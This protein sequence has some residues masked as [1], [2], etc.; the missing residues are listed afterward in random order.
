MWRCP[1]CRR[2]FANRNQSHFCGNYELGTHFEGKSEA[3]GKLY[4]KFVGRVRRFGPVIIMPEKTRIAF[5]VRMSFAAVQIRRSALVGHLVLAE[6]NEQP[7]FWRID[8]ISRRNHVHH[9][10]IEKATDLDEEFCRFIRKAY[11]V[12]QQ[13][14]L[15]HARDA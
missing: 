15:R 5:Q 1:E 7:C 10:R 9:F 3:V 8:S 2:Q 14:H 12:G 6:R 11:A 4:K 13:K